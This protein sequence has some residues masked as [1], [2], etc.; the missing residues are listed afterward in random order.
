MP[1]CGLV[2][3]SQAR[4][5]HDD[6]LQVEVGVRRIRC[7][8]AQAYQGQGLQRRSVSCGQRELAA[9]LELAKPQT[10]R[11]VPHRTVY[12]TRE[13][14]TYLLG[15]KMRQSSSRKIHTFIANVPRLIRSRLLR[16]KT[17]FFK[18]YSIDPEIQN[19]AFKLIGVDRQAG[20]KK[21]NLILQG[22]S[23]DRY[24]ENRGMFSE[25]L[26]LF[27]PFQSQKTAASTSW[28]LE[29]TTVGPQKF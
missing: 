23:I 2:M 7:P 21:L 24:N 15:E 18:T 8:G 6:V 3:C 26:P 25:H 9:R 10:S 29:H 11:S 17:S 1:V 28:K 14:T 5:Q 22:M 4:D 20:I 19:K 27:L 12:L 16:L 13:T